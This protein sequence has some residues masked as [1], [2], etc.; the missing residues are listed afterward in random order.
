MYLLTIRCVLE[1]YER[2]G[3]DTSVSFDSVHRVTVPMTVAQTLPDVDIPTHAVDK[4]PQPF[5]LVDEMMCEIVDL[6]MCD[7]FQRELERDRARALSPAS[8]CDQPCSN[9]CVLR[10]AQKMECFLPAAC[11]AGNAL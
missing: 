9:A 5:R 10:Q 7:I 2:V 8:V 6:A 3:S 4:L 1:I 11:Y